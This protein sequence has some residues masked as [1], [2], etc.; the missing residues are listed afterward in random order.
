MC[1]D[2]KEKDAMNMRGNMSIHGGNEKHEWEES[3]I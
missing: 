3:N 2:K 1:N